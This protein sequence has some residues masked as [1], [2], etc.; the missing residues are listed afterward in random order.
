MIIHSLNCK[1]VARVII[2]IKLGCWY[3]LE[4]VAIALL[5]LVWVSIFRQSRSVLLLP[6][7]RSL[8]V[9]FKSLLFKH[10]LLW[11]ASLFVFLSSLASLI[12]CTHHN[13]VFDFKVNFLFFWPI[14]I[15]NSI[16][17]FGIVLLLFSLPFIRLSLC[18]IKSVLFAKY[19]SLLQINFIL[20]L[21]FEISFHYLMSCLFFVLHSQ[22]VLS[23]F[24]MLFA[25]K[26][27]FTVRVARSVNLAGSVC[28][29][30]FPNI[31]PFYLLVK[32]IKLIDV[33]NIFDLLIWL[34]MRLRSQIKSL[35]SLSAPTINCFLNEFIR[36]HISRLH[37]GLY[38]QKP[39]CWSI[40]EVDVLLDTVSCDSSRIIAPCLLWKQ[41]FKWFLSVVIVSLDSNFPEARILIR[42]ACWSVWA[43]IESVSAC[44]KSILAHHWLKLLIHLW[45][46]WPRV[47]DTLEP[48]LC[49]P[50]IL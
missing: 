48:R 49:I 10:H 8:Y 12:D 26:V 31:K 3:V 27:L 50:I 14:Q 6:W 23:N 39:C 16:D 4:F 9:L 25:L 24:I 36:G 47:V 20:D 30:F 21:L 5:L 33:L 45:Q 40:F 38:A 42:S 28:S 7:S 11:D 46:I 35:V 41:L 34:P 2:N 22:K 17:V 43:K 44:V 37:P 29:H 15:L 18:L 13:I 1:V 19:D 32:I